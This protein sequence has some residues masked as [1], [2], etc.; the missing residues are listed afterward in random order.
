MTTPASSLPALQSVVDIEIPGLESYGNIPVRIYTPQG[1]GPFGVTIYIHGGGWGA[2][3][4]DSHDRICRSMTQRSGHITVS[5]GYHL[6]PAAVYPTQ[7]HECYAAL[8]WV[9]AHAATFNGD[10][11]RIAIAGD[12]AGGNLATVTALRAIRTPGAPKINLQVLIY[13]MLDYYNPE[14]D[15][16]RRYGKGLAVTTELSKKVYDGYLPNGFDA[17]DSYIFP[18]RM[19]KEDLARMPPALVVLAEQDILVDEGTEYVQKLQEVGVSAEQVIVPEVQHS[20]LIPAEEEEKSQSAMKVIA[21]AIRNA[22]N[23][24]KDVKA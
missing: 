14:R 5:V 4:I 3:S 9:H 6:V 2:L 23:T 11:T 7:T 22:H 8:E 10:P 21:T 20:F 24:P 19:P 17:Q 15:S 13:P 16:Y 18:L 1:D 12:S